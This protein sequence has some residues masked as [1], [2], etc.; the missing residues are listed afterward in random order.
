MQ[1][2]IALTKNVNFFISPEK[3]DLTQDG[4]YDSPISKGGSIKRKQFTPITNHAKIAPCIKR[5]YKISAQK[6]LDMFA[7]FFRS[8]IDNEY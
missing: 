7:S 6:L 8:R 1:L 2:N 3:K 4:I 5:M